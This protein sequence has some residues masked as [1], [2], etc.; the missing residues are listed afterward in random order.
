MQQ[1]E[2]GE[3]V[4]PDERGRYYAPTKNYGVPHASSTGVYIEGLIDAWQLA[5][6]LGDDE[7][8]EY[9]RKSLIRGIR[10]MMQLQFV[11]DVDMYYV[12]DRKYVEGGIRTTVFDNRIRC[13]NVQHPMMGIIKVVRFFDADEY[14]N[15]Q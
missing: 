7:R 9:Y 6:D 10:E 3:W 14:G 11:D 1:W 4:Y 8:R 5:R 12:K 2:D 13:D 15:A